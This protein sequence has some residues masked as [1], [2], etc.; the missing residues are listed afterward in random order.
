MHFHSLVLDGVCDEAGDFTPSNA[1]TLDDMDRL[2]TTIA[3]RIVRMCERRA[4]DEEHHEELALLRAISRSARRDGAS[5]HGPE[6][7]DPDHDAQPEWGGKL[8]ARVDGFDLE[9]TTVVSGDDRERLEHLCK[10]VLRPPLV[11]RRLRLLD[12]GRVAIELKTP[13]KD[14]RD[15]SRRA[16]ERGVRTAVRVARAGQAVTVTSTA[17]L[18]GDDEHD[19]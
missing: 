9:C 15:L 6:G 3:T 11:D 16:G 17:S 13:W 2:T 10:Y 14:G 5:R 1:P 19:V 18:R 12:D 7:T 4:L 8:K